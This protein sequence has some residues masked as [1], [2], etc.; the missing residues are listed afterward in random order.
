MCFSSSTKAGLD[1]ITSFPKATCVKPIP[2]PL[3]ISSIYGTRLKALE[4]AIY[5]SS[6]CTYLDIAPIAPET[7]ERWDISPRGQHITERWE[8]KTYIS[9]P[10]SGVGG[11]YC[12]HWSMIIQKVSETNVTTPTYSRNRDCFLIRAWFFSLEIAPLVLCFPQLSAPTFAVLSLPLSL[13]TSEDGIEKHIFWG[14]VL[15]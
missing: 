2:G 3:K 11:E 14:F 5:V 7:Y 6:T 13:A 8:Q 1:L 15:V 4:F 9:T 12:S 10:I